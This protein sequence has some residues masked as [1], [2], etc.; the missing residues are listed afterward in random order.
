[1]F[2]YGGTVPASGRYFGGAQQWF[3]TQLIPE[4]HPVGPA[5][6]GA[7]VNPN[8]LSAACSVV[9]AEASAAFARLAD[10]GFRLPE[11]T[12]FYPRVRAEREEPWFL[13]IDFWMTLDEQGK[14]R[15]AWRRDTPFE[16]GGAAAI[17]RE[18]NGEVVRY[19]KP[20]VPVR[21]APVR[22]RRAYASDGRDRS[23]GGHRG[24]VGRNRH[25][26]GQ[27]GIPSAEVEDVMTHDEAYKRAIDLIE[28]HMRLAGR[29]PSDSGRRDADWREGIGYLDAA[30]RLVPNNWAAWWVRGKAQQALG[31]HEAAY[32]SLRRAYAINSG[33]VDVGREF[34]V[35]PFG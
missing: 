8:A 2:Q 3:S 20:Y 15:T 24:L 17:T 14:Y 10:R 13:G 35:A 30:L 11:Q 12:G 16:L 9:R 18:E 25:R 19:W 1:M 23:G 34:V 31:D 33:H 22:R 7:A 4:Q 32:E 6:G 28:P 27:A 5:V 29:K 21:L 26:D